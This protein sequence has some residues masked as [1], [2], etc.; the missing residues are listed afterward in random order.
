MVVLGL[1][2]LI[3]AG[4]FGAAV[5]TSNTSPGNGDL[6]GLHV[7]TLS[8]GTVYLA[9]LVTG[10]VALFALVMLAAGIRRGRRLRL[11]RRALAREN[12][13]LA[14]HIGTAGGTDPGWPTRQ[15]AAEENHDQPVDHPGPPVGGGIRYGSPPPPS[16]DRATIEAEAY[17]R[18]TDDD[19]ATVPDYDTTGPMDAPPARRH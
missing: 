18:N 6:W 8:L 4:V 11:E 17:R 7:S 1:L 3:G 2:L 9:G 12:A 13:R 5:I 10:I 16:Y 19:Y 15:A 14:Q